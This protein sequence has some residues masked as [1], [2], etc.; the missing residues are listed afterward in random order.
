VPS[1]ADRRIVIGR[2]SGLS[3]LRGW[4]KLFSY[5]DPRSN[6]LSFREVELGKEGEW[7][8]AR[9]IEGRPQGKTL[10]GRFEG[11]EDRDQAA[12]LLDQEIAIRRSQLP[13]E[14]GGVYWTDLIGLEVINVRE[15]SL[16]IVD[17][18]I[19]TGANDV[20]VVSGERERLIPF[21]RDT[22]VKEIDQDRGCI[23]VDW[24]KDY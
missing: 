2:V 8:R 12:G 10:I 24:E 14:S 19:E 21:V 22:V 1:R 23:L 20:M 9:L 11:V 3:G 6:L 18:L 17:H 7:K 4:V 13:E 5:T 16:G 15:E